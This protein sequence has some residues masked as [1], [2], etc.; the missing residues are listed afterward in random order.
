MTDDGF[1]DDDE[2]VDAGGVY[3]VCGGSVGN[4]GSDDGDG[5]DWFS[6]TAKLPFSVAGLTIVAL[7]S[8]TI[9]RPGVSW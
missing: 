9:K 2:L 8:L 5:A 1:D 3:G 4:G 7:L 6:C